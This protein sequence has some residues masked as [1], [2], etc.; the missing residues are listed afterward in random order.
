MTNKTKNCVLSRADCFL[1]PGMNRAYRFGV[2]VLAVFIG[3][4]FT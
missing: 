3:C 4:L 1:R 2:Q